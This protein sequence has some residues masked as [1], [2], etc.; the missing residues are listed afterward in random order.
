VIR[1]KAALLFVLKSLVFSMVFFFTVAGFYLII[2]PFRQPND[3]KMSSSI[4]MEEY[5]RQ[6]QES[7]KSME[8]QKALLKRTEDNMI[9]Q[10]RNTKRMSVILDMWE[11]QLK[12]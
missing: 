8:K 3:S 11:K 7:A 12:K 10:E 1:I 2:S 9:E 5:N 4:N 6:I